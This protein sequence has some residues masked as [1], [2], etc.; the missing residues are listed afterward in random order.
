MKWFLLSL[1]AVSLIF[2]AAPIASAGFCDPSSCTGEYC[3]KA[4]V[5]INTGSSLEY[6]CPGETIEVAV[7]LND[8][9][10]CRDVFTADVRYKYIDPDLGHGIGVERRARWARPEMKIPMLP[11][12]PFRCSYYVT[13]PK[14][15][16]LGEYIAIMTVEGENSGVV[17]KKRAKFT[18]G[19]ASCPEGALAENRFGVCGLKI[20]NDSNLETVSQMMQDADLKWSRY[21]LRWD[22]IVDNAGSFNWDELDGQIE[23]IYSHG[24][25][26]LLV[27]RSIHEVF[28]PDSGMVDLGHKIVWR[29]APPAPEYL[30]Q[31]KDF[32]RQT[33]ERYDGDGILDAPFINS[34][35]KISYWGVETEPGKIPDQGSSF[36]NG[37]AADYADLYLVAYDEIKAMDRKARIVLSAFT[38]ASVK[39]YV[40]NGISFPSEVLR[41]L[42][43]RGGDFDVFNFHFYKVYSSY[44][45]YHDAVVVHLELFDEFRRKPIWI[46]ETNMEWAQLDPDYT[47]EQYN[48]FV[49]KDM[50]KRFALMFEKGVRKVSWFTTRDKLGDWVNPMAPGDFS[51]FSGLTDFDMTPKPV[52]YTYDLLTDKLKGRVPAIRVASDPDTWVFRFGNDDDSV[53]VMWADTTTPTD[54]TV[55]IPWEQAQITYAITEP[56]VTEPVI[57]T[58]SAVGGLLQIGLDDWPIFVENS[59]Q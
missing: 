38:A 55:S 31:Y 23:K 51:R 4:V 7:T 48:A 46:T 20:T 13:L 29:S 50:V 43:E 44:Y 34:D 8:R 22:E 47:A 54:V 2:G 1:L 42:H 5:R 14:G 49:A 27:F 26:M 24:I 10:G 9:M 19:G 28:A 40:N 45:E 6:A 30:E 37:T 18:V 32:V 25:K 53:Y 58:R 39:Y 11:D 52:Y 56:G 59:I 17:V 41:I 15:I 33:V 57:E 3:V 12:S 36:W 16:S 21:T 35:T